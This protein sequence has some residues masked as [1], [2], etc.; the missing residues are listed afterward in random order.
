MVWHWRVPLVCLLLVG[1]GR[2]DSDEPVRS[3]PET[4]AV[5]VEQAR[6]TG[7]AAALRALAALDDPDPWLVTDALLA[8]GSFDAAQAFA[9]AAPRPD[10][11]TL[12][13]YVQA[14]RDALEDAPARRALLAATAANDEGLG[15]AALASL[16]ALPPE[17]GAGSVLG[18]RLALERA[19]ALRTLGR[20]AESSAALASAAEVA[21]SLGWVAMAAMAWFEAGSDAFNATP[22]DARGAVAHW[23]QAL[24]HLRARG[25]RAYEAG[26]LQNMGIAHASL[27]EWQL[28]LSLQEQALAL[29]RALHD[30]AAEAFSL[31]ALGAL[32][33]DL[34]DLGK[35]LE[36][37]RLEHAIYLQLESENDAAQ[38][39]AELGDTLARRGEHEQ[40]LDHL[41]RALAAQRL[42]PDQEGLARSLELLGLVQVARGEVAQGLESLSQALARREAAADPGPLAQTL[43]LMA[44]VLLRRG[45]YAPAAGLVLRSAKA[46]E[47]SADPAA[48]A[49]V[50]GAQAAVHLSLGD[51]R[52]ALEHQERARKGWEALGRR[53]ELGF[54]LTRL[55]SVRLSLGDYPTALQDLETARSLGAALG[56]RALGAEALAGMA[57]VHFHLGD[58]TSA[59]DLYERARTIYEA[60]EQRGA[61]AKILGNLGATYDGLRAFPKALALLHQ[62]ATTLEALGDRP[63]AAMALLNMAD[64]Q[65]E[66]GSPTEALPLLERSNRI[67]EDLKDRPGALAVLLGRGAVHLQLGEPQRALALYEKADREAFA[68]RSM[69]RYVLAL[70]GAAKARLDLGEPAV[71]LEVAKRALEALEQLA[72]GQSEEQG[73]SART[74]YA[75]LYDAGARA[76]LSQKDVFQAAFFLESGRGMTLL[77]SLGGR[78]ALEAARLTPELREAEVRVRADEA[79]AHRDHLATLATP[80]PLA[81]KDAQARHDAQARLEAAREATRAVIEQIARAC[82]AQTA[83]LLFPRAATLEELQATLR[84]TEA[85]VIFALLSTDAVALV[86]TTEAARLVRLGTSADVRA[87]CEA[88]TPSDSSSD[89]EP[90]IARLTATL[91]TPLA[92]DAKLTRVI[93]SPDGVLAY[94]PFTL[95]LGTREVAYAPSGTVYGTL[96]A[97]EHERG[98][99]ILALGDPDYAAG[100]ARGAPGAGPDPVAPAY[101]RNSRRLTPLKATRAEAQAIGDKVLLGPEAT[102]AGLK[103]ALAT[104]P[105]WRAVHFAC[106]GRLDPD[107][108]LLC[109][110][111]LTADGQDDGDL[112]LYEILRQRVAAD[113][114][115]L[116]ACESGKGRIF[117]G[118]G[119]LGLSRVFMVAGAPRV[120]CSLWKVDDDATAALMKAFY[121]RWKAGVPAAR[122][123]KEAQDLVRS[124]EEWKH[125]SFWAAWV[126]WGLPE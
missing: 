63:A 107:R 12:P 21:A 93:L 65:R 110:L 58:Y 20:R 114:V 97:E 41:Q 45:D 16:A 112:T 121:E 60:L 15:E 85:L 26:A 55:A 81:E 109:S 19:R 106:H 30:P 7:E 116:S 71:A 72:G 115:T 92:L 126:L 4:A 46:A 111:A 59:L 33:R 61:A 56:L 11:G 83:G 99:K 22:C 82:K 79:A 3:T 42:L 52:R 43:A 31:H 86:L 24:P 101:P 37:Q 108:L 84:P 105:R 29:R 73:A 10:V 57:S 5:A 78:D 68:L 100:P 96:R 80:L 91:V 48:L 122:A 54:S 40:A 113:L 66:L 64:V 14:R 76:A 51:L 90:A 49:V 94:L 69:D 62:A 36:A 50:A 118:E 104:R 17:A 53:A 23:A 87:A 39:L 123:L 67:Y 35:A 89:V 44:E 77:E 38:A 117:S 120:L 102:E 95:L 103:A 9:R 25:D 2:L 32:Y 1:G 47:A 18:A 119:L 75:D 6:S 27:G 125:P 13:A 70:I 74:L 28:G 124:R 8:R 34:G 88:F 98:E